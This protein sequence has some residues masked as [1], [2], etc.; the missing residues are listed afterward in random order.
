MLVLTITPCSFYVSQN[1]SSRLIYLEKDIVLLFINLHFDNS[2]YSSNTAWIEFI[3]LSNGMK[4][5]LS[6]YKQEFID[7]QEEIVDYDKSIRKI[8]EN[9]SH[10]L[11]II[12]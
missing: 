6:S 3:N 11:Q 8:I 1:L 12:D 5:S 4:I 2:K 9:R 7:I 10:I